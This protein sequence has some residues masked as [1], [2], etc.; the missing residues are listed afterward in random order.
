MSLSHPF[1][2]AERSSPSCSVAPQPGGAQV[3]L[4]NAGKDATKLF[5]SLHPKNTLQDNAD[6]LVKV[7]VV[8]PSGVCLRQP[9]SPAGG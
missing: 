6:L 9:G 1:I 4:S 3:I 7:G 2:L 8:D 5:K